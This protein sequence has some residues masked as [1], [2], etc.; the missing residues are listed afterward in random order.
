MRRD[1]KAL[2][3]RIGAT[4]IYVTHDQSEALGL[5][6]RIAVFNGGRLQQYDAPEVIYNSP[7][8]RFVANFVGERGMNFIEG[9]LQMTG[10]DC[11]FVAPAIDIAVTEPGAQTARA[12]SLGIRLEGVRPARDG[13]TPEALAKVDQV[14]LSGP[15]KIVM[16]TLQGGQ[17]VTCR[18]DAM[19]QVHR[20]DTLPLVFDRGRLNFF[21]AESGD[22]LR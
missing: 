20:G 8:N 4:T 6:D 13:E 17:D 2:H 16:T 18:T 12:A 14:E 1:I 11:R 19:I 21:D 5:S 10:G 7:A 15:D 22:A 3:D 9:E